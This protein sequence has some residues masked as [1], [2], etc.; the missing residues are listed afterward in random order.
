M[1]MLLPSVLALAF[2]NEVPS[3]NRSIGVVPAAALLPAVA[4][5]LP[6]AETSCALACSSAARVEPCPCR[7]VTAQ[8]WPSL[9]DRLGCFVPC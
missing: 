2:P 6:T 3:A 9:G 8:L 5:V 1:G 7:R 4:L